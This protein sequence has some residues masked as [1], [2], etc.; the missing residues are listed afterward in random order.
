MG[1][2]VMTVTAHPAALRA[3]VQEMIYKEFGVS[4]D[5]RLEWRVLRFNDGTRQSVCLGIR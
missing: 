2:G 1:N 5:D 3:D 4:E